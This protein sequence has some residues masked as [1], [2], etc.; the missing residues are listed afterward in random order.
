MVAAEVQGVADEL[1]E[2]RYLFGRS[3]LSIRCEDASFSRRFQDLFAECAHDFKVGQEIPVLALRVRYVPSNPEVLAVSMVPSLIDGVEFVQRLFPEREYVECMGLAPGWRT[4]A[5]PKAPQEPVLAFGQNTILVSSDHPWQHMVAAYAIDNA[6]RIQPDLLVF[7]AASVAVDG[8]GVLLLGDKGAGKTTLSLC[9]ASRGHAF[10]GDEWGAVSTSTRELLP[11][12]SLL[13]IRQGP[14][15]AG[16][17]EYLRGQSCRVEIL[18][19]GTKRVRARAGE[20]FPHS[21]PQ[22]VPLTHVFFLR[23]SAAR[24]AVEEFGRDKA[25]LLRASPLLA[26]IRGHSTGRLALELLRTLGKA[27]LWHL[28]VGGSPDETADV[29]E[30]TVREDTYGTDSAR[31][32]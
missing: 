23:R 20:M 7:H 27:R 5:L 29:I 14:R 31:E 4:L 10:L 22:V 2:K 30:K 17:D 19:D 13:S 16:V 8:H 1:C 12:R 26:T 6:F 3:L 24:P 18:R 32:S 25:E 15:A 28:D 11:M 9:L 21:S